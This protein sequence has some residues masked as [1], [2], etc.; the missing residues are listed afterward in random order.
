MG[1]WQG[2]RTS[3]M[4]SLVRIAGVTR[5][6]RP[7]AGA[8]LLP[9][10]LLWTAAGLL[11]LLVASNGEPHRI[12]SGYYAA[13]VAPFLILVRG[14]GTVLRAAE[15]E[16]NR[17]IF[18]A[19]LLFAAGNLA[20]TIVTPT[21]ESIY[22]LLERCI[23]PLFV[24]LSLVGLRLSPRDVRLLVLAVAAGGLFMFVRGLFAYYQEF[25]IPDLQT[26]LWSRYDTVRIAGFEHATLGNVTHIGNYVA[27]VLPILIAG[28]VSIAFS[29]WQRLMLALTIVLGLL[30]LVVAGS[31]AGML[32]MILVG[33][34]IAYCFA[35]RRTL[36]I[37]AAAVMVIGIVISLVA[38][39]AGDAELV[40]RFA[41]GAS[42]R[43]DGSVE[44]RIDSMVIGWQVFLD[45]AIFGVGPAMSSYHNSYSIP[46][47]SI[48]HQLSELGIFGGLAFIWLN[49]V[50]IYAFGRSMMSVASH[51]ESSFR[52]LWLIGPGA[53][54]IL[55]LYSGIVFNMSMA[56]VWI[57]IV[58][59]M[60]AISG[61]T[62][63]DEDSRRPSFSI[64][65]LLRG[66]LRK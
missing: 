39:S 63:A 61:A 6:A 11:C 42:G 65:S 62:V 23:L 26:L 17:Q 12:S 32:V 8:A 44:E 66:L 46:H 47:Q 15:A 55:G 2:E 53:W 49:I 60:L 59:A 43:I 58:H 51:A 54:L 27:L 19:L 45:N 33:V 1:Y 4:A 20:S 16:P 40:K 29:S 30:T 35:S 21:E 3:V 31:R 28:L 5:E 41:P 14:A 13:L 22:A 34:A 38:S 57:G 50:V 52:F 37:F 18:Y 25:G 64:L 10:L 24:Y 9:S 56:L 7:A 36:A 48:L